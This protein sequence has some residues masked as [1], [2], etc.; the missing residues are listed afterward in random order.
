MDALLRAILDE[1]ASITPRLVEVRRRIHE[2]PELSGF[3]FE[4]SKLV[5]AELGKLGVRFRRVGPRETGIWATLDGAA[6]AIALR[7]DL[8][9]LP[10]DETH[11][12]SVKSKVPG[13]AHTCGHDAHTTIV[14][15]AAMILTRLGAARGRRVE[16][17]FQHAEEQD[18]GAHDFVGAGAMRGVTEVYG[19]HCD[20]NVPAG[21]IAVHARECM[22]AV[23]TYKITFRG[24][25]GHGAYVYD[26][27]DPIV[28]ASQFVVAAQTIASRRMD[29]LD[30]AVF[31]V[32]KFVAGTKDNIVPE[33]AHLEATLRTL[34]P[35][36]RA[37]AR[38]E[39][40]VMARAV[41]A[42]VEGAGV[43]IVMQEGYPPTINHSKGVARVQE[44]AIRLFG[45]EAFHVRD[46]P[47]MGSEDFSRYLE[48]APGA[49]VWLGMGR[50]GEV[51]PYCHSPLFRLDEA[52]LPRGAALLAMLA[53]TSPGS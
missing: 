39:V 7:G 32:G 42:S 36:A 29:P 16:L 43:D 17:F 40:E 53:L 47:E 5:A 15:G 24:K 52:I 35:Q 21:T 3:E 10:M 51:T 41:A 2:H 20:P 14:L 50:P 1:A 34:S 44:A 4:T 33:V 30:P 37:R 13:V 11:D 6:N 45:A 27:I 46:K 23:D 25:G 18:G 28:L 38:R 26:A 19:V 48:C 12:D 8:D 31:S 49:F 9:A 22:A